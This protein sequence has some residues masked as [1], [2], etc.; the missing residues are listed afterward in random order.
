VCAHDQRDDSSIQYSVDIRTRA[1]CICF[2]LSARPPAKSRL[3][4][5]A[6]VCVYNN[7]RWGRICRR[8]QFRH[9][10]AAPLEHDNSNR[11]LICSVKA[12]EIALLERD[13]PFC[14]ILLHVSSLLQYW[15]SGGK[16]VLGCV[17]GVSVIQ[18]HHMDADENA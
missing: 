2:F 1:A 6:S 11:R 9:S 8:R 3:A 16:L 13:G 4:F 15:F 12:R 17:G 5:S 18:I 7:A 14:Y 10:A